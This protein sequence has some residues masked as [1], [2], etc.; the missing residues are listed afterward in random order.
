MDIL[1]EIVRHKKSEVEMRREQVSV[2]DLQ[3]SEFYNRT[4]VSMVAHLRDPEKSGIIA[5]FKRKSPS[6]GIINDRAEVG[7]VTQ[8]YT[9]AGAS[10]L[11]VLTDQVFFGGTSEDLIK[12]RGANSC[13]ILRKDFIIDPYQ[14]Y[15]T[16]S[17]GADVIL[18]IA[19]ILGQAQLKEL[20]VLA[21]GLGLEILMEVHT[22]EELAK[23]C[24][25]VDI[26]GVN[27]RNLVTFD[28]SIENSKSLAAK[29]PAGF[30]KISES[31]IHTSEHIHA[32]RSY[33]FEGFLV[34]ERF[35]ATSDPIQACSDFISA[36]KK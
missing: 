36:T 9:R 14:V 15:E 25:E 18:L 26:L 27:N 17:I 8:G 28:T 35:M 33:G 2:E 12:A 29:I 13:P 30:L 6:K 10:G 20:A 1:N 5:E 11:S 19:R 4:T 3:Q 21:K 22:E 24:D 23:A 7:Q 34:G 31:G 32:L 16:K